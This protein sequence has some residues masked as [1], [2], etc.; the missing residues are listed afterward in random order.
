MNYWQGIRI[1][2]N[3]FRLT[4]RLVSAC[5]FI[6]LVGTLAACRVGGEV[7]ADSSQLVVTGTVRPPAAAS[8]SQR[9]VVVFLDAREVG[10]AVAKCGAAGCPFRIVIPN[11]YGVI[12]QKNEPGGAALFDVGEMAEEE[13]RTFEAPARPGEPGRSRHIYAAYALAGPVEKL[14]PELLTGRLGVSPESR[15]VVIG[16]APSTLSGQDIT[17]PQRRF[18]IIAG[19]LLACLA[20]LT[21]F[22][23]GAAIVAL[24]IW[25]R[26]RHPVG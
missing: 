20:C 24:V 14:Q 13:P 1:F 26:R 8:G 16:P 11:L 12:G 3:I 18:L 19:L 17:D 10:R 9:L 23:A 22:I 2:Q 5:L 7:T 15:I 25:S 4:T 21:L 6:W